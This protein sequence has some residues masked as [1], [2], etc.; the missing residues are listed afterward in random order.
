MIRRPPRSTLF[1]YTTLFRSVDP[2]L[3]A[4]ELP[5]A[6]EHRRGLVGRRQLRPQLRER[7]GQLPDTRS[8]LALPALAELE[9]SRTERFRVGLPLGL[10]LRL[11][12][13]AELGPRAKAAEGAS[14]LPHG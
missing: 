13:P 7:R 6:V 12:R 2:P 8:Q 5:E 1:P 10:E 9:R 4:H 14:Q 11:V 3:L